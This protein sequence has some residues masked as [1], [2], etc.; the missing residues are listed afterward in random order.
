MS[1]MRLLSSPQTRWPYTVLDSPAL[2]YNAQESRDWFK[3]AC[4]G[5]R[6][7][8]EI[9]VSPSIPTSCFDPR[10]RDGATN[11]RPPSV[12][13]EQCYVSGGVWT[14]GAAPGAAGRLAQPGVGVRN[15][16]G[17]RLVSQRGIRPDLVVVTLPAFG[18]DFRLLQR[19]KQFCSLTYMFCSQHLIEGGATD[20]GHC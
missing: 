12:I 16:R 4:A 11:G 2:A 10:S 13:Q 5:K 14:S 3:P 17:W 8:G 20:D 9:K 1:L 18:D 15:S 6:V 7:C 19:W